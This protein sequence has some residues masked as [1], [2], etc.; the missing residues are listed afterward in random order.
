MKIDIS[1][2]SDELQRFIKQYPQATADSIEVFSDRVGFTL[3]G[4][5]KREAPAITGNLRR[6]IIYADRNVAGFMNNTVQGT[7]TS[8]ARY[9]SYVH[10][11]PFHKNKMR[12]R[13][14]P[15]FTNAIK[16]KETFIKDEARAIMGRVLK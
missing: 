15:F 4:Q 8:H 14:T 5:A 2:E 3:E 11:H 7:L 1:L 10:G 9:S 12:R 13:E 6:N 16:A